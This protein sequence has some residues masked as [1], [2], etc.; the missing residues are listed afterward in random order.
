MGSLPIPERYPQ[1]LGFETFVRESRVQH[2][3]KELPLVV[4][5]NHRVE[6]PFRS[7]DRYLE[8]RQWRSPQRYHHDQPRYSC[9]DIEDITRNVK[10]ETPNSDGRLDPSAFLN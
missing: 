2:V 3:G 10:V 7:L 4:P 8:R 1:P 5:I 6:G 9:K